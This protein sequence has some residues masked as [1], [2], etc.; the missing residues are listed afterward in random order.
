MRL[1]RCGGVDENR[2]YRPATSEHTGAG[3]PVDVYGAGSSG[4]GDCCCE[5]V[6][7][8]PGRSPSERHPGPAAKAGLVSP[9]VREL[10]S[11]E[12]MYVRVAGLDVCRA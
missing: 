8:Y 3:E 2:G 1:R 4:A 10:S 12:V 9:V 6:G 7:L 11:M 5:H